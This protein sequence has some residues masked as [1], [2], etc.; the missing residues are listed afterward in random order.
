MI[1]LSDLVRKT[2]VS[3][4]QKTIPIKVFGYT[5]ED[6]EDIF[7]TSLNEYEQY[8][9][10]K[11][12]KILSLNLDGVFLIDADRVLSVKFYLNGFTEYISSMDFRSWEFHPETKKLTSSFGGLYEV[13]YVGKYIPEFLSISY[14]Q[15]PLTTFEDKAKFKLKELFKKGTLAISVVDNSNPLVPIVYQMT[16]DVSS[17]QFLSSPFTV[18]FSSD[19]LTVVESLGKKFLTGSKVKIET[20]GVFPL[21]NG[22][23]L[24]NQD[25]YYLIKT[26]DIS[27]KLA[28][29]ISDALNNNPIIFTDSG[30]GVHTLTS[31]AELPIISLVGSLG[32]GTVNL[33][34]LEVD[35]TFSHSMN[36]FLNIDFKAANVGVS[37]LDDNDS[38]FLKL[39]KAN[40]LISLGMNK[41]I[42]KTD[43][44]PWD[45]SA[46]DLYN[47]GEK[48]K[49]EIN[50]ELTDKAKWWEF[51]GK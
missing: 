26:S 19:I 5:T 18:D 47:K 29:T 13:V 9:P 24:N 2:L 37:T 8:R 15:M 21:A 27:F 31:Q 7:R 23:T 35:L 43:N 16:D 1:T 17:Y 4:G 6:L 45:F 39:F 30:T 44:L 40:F 48:L 20:T 22:I 32:T 49:E 33:S 46:D 25:F 12:T 38:L 28:R 41:S 10:N 36:G 50:Q 3:T 34:N 14:S 51:K 42:L 11:V